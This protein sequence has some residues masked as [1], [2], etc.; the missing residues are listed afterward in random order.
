MAVGLDFNFTVLAVL[1]WMAYAG[2]G[3]CL[4]PSALKLDRC[5]ADIRFGGHFPSSGADHIDGGAGNDFLWIDGDDTFVQGGDG[6]DIVI[7]E[8]VKPVTIDLYTA[9][10]EVI[11]CGPGDD[12]VTMSGGDYPVRGKGPTVRRPSPRGGRD[13]MHQHTKC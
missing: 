4:L 1:S 2:A 5:G 7:V 9:G 8:G 10:I 11:Y 6:F 12:V 3:C 13:D